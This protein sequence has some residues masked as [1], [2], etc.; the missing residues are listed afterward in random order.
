MPLLWSACHSARAA[1]ICGQKAALM[2]VNYTPLCATQLLPDKIK[3]LQYRTISLFI[4]RYNETYRMII[5]IS[6]TEIWSR[7][8]FS[9]ACVPIL[10]KTSFPVHGTYLPHFSSTQL[11]SFLVS[12]GL[13]LR[14][15][16][17]IAGCYND[18]GENRSDTHWLNIKCHTNITG[19]AYVFFCLTLECGYLSQWLGRFIW[20][21]VE[22]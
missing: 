8:A 4:S 2:L 20:E 10:T 16:Q 22:G 1:D 5:S 18:V 15:K 6:S 21:E 9:L 12:V 19:D 7:T 3:H 11:D 17:Y 13:L 14:C